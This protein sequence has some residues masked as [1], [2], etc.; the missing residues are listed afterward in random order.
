MSQKRIL[1]VDDE[2]HVLAGLQNMLRKERHVWDMVFTSS[3]ANALEELAKGKFDVIVSD[4]RMPGMDGAALLARVKDEHPSVAR[5]VLSGHAERDAVERAIPVAHQFLSKPC[6]GAILRA[7]IERTCRL[8]AL[9]QDESI[10]EIV[11]R[12]A[13]LPSAPSAYFELTRVLGRPDAGAHDVASIIERDPAMAAKVL[14]LVNSA[15]FGLAQHIASI[16]RAVSYLG[17]EVLKGLALSAHVFTAF[18]ESE[19]GGF[20]IEA[21][22]LSSLRVAR[23]AK[24]LVRDS[25]RGEEA[26]SAGIVH[27]VGKI[28]LAV[29]LRERYARIYAAEGGSLGD[30]EQAEFG[31][32]HAEVGAYLLGV[33]GLPLTV[34]ETV[35]FHHRPSLVTAPDLQVLA[36]VHVADVFLDHGANDPEPPAFDVEFLARAGVQVDLERWRAL[37]SE[38]SPQR[39]GDRS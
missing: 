7:V 12:L 33:W 8:Q 28:V 3:A 20:S 17:T 2:A 14:Q 4:M 19:T 13:Q 37:A 24:R 23:L 22:Q 27:D 16:Q 36:A 6:D 11:G 15:Y 5:L 32:T 29:A 34:V 9:L 10:R 25:A 30:R 1:F 21:I 39:N 35:A 31:L 18:G 26:F 38:S